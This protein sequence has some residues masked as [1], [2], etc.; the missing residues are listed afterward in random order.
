MKEAAARNRA[1]IMSEVGA[2][3]QHQQQ[4]QQQ[5]EL[6]AE[7]AAEELE[8]AAMIRDMQV[9]TCTHI[10]TTYAGRRSSLG[11]LLRG[12]QCS[13]AEGTTI[14]QEVL[15]NDSEGGAEPGAGPGPRVHDVMDAEEEAEAE[16]DQA[17]MD[18]ADPQAMVS[19]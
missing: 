3:H 5:P 17:L 11:A 15:V 12:S 2:S 8:F 18:G 4:Q 1:A 10:C 16:E 7:A 9:C 6:Q 13:C 14:A 19:D